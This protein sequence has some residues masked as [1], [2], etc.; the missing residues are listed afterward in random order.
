MHQVSCISVNASERR[1]QGF[2]C[3]FI[4]CQCQPTV[5]R[6]YT[7]AVDAMWSPD[8]YFVHVESG[9][10]FT[11]APLGWRAIRIIFLP[12]MAFSIHDSYNGLLLVIP[13]SVVRRRYERLLDI[14]L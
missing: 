11:L 14:K 10:F 3:L 6:G 12:R 7:P 13:V 2:F 4:F 8:S 5:Q 9:G 1:G